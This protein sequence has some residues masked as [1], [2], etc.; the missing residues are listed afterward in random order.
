M[1]RGGRRL[2]DACL[3]L[4][5]RDDPKPALVQLGRVARGGVRAAR[6]R[7]AASM[8]V[9]KLTRPVRHG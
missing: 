5:A 7:A 4:L 3:R 9:S 2:P 1:P 6:G 8:A